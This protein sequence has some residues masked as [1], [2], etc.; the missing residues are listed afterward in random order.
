[1]R[2]EPARDDII[3]VSVND[4]SSDTQ[5]RWPSLRRNECMNRPTMPAMNATGRKTAINESDVASTASPTSR[6][7]STAACIGV[8]F[9]SSMKRKMFSSTTT[10]SSMTMPDGQRQRQQRDHVQRE[11][12]VSH[13]AERGDDRTG[14]G[15]REMIVGRD[16]RKK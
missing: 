8:R 11:V 1:M 14:D 7:P 9:F 4:T 3:G 15:H 5:W 10:A 16:L 12:L 2:L 13:R 6:V